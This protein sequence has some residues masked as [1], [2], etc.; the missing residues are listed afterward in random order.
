MKEDEMKIK[1]KINLD[2][3]IAISNHLEGKATK[4]DCDFISSFLREV[5]DKVFNKAA[6]IE[7]L[8]TR[9]IDK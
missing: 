9:F 2:Q 1:I 5:H 7:N 4:E 8:G 3:H 6:F